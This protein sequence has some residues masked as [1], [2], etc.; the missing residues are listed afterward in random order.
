MHLY[1]T[2]QQR[3]SKVTLTTLFIGLVIYFC[4][5]AAS[6]D[7]GFFTMLSLQSTL[8]EKRMELDFA[9]AERIGLEHKVT[10]MQ[11]DS[12]DLDLLDEQ[13]RKVLV[14]ASPN[15]EIFFYRNTQEK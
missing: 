8:E 11:S 4:Y 6:G 14:Y 1:K 12:L 13:V 3:F 10:L 7:R 15:E 9:R 2:I 5:H